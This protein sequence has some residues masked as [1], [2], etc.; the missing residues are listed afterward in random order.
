VGEKRK[1][2]EPQD[3][4][5]EAGISFIISWDGEQ[6]QMTGVEERTLEKGRS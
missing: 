5:A 3:K 6:S 1:M 4:D 2:G